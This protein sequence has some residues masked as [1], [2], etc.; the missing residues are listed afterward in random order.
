MQG[1]RGIMS[2]TTKD[3][4]QMLLFDGAMGTYY[5]QRYQ[6]ET[7]AEEA[8]LSHPDQII[9]IHKAY[10]EA[11]ARVIRTNTFAINHVLFPDQKMAK[12]ALVQAVSHARRAVEESG[13]EVVIAGSIGPIRQD[14]LDTD[15]AVEAEYK[16]LVAAFMEQ[17]I[18]TIMLETFSQP[19][20]IRMLAEWIKKEYGKATLLVSFSVGLSGYTKFGFS[21]Q[22]LIN[23]FFSMEEIDA[24]GFN[25]G[26]GAA[27]LKK[28]LQSVTF[29]FEKP[30]FVLPNA[31]YQHEI[32]GRL[33]YAFDTAYY[34]KQMEE[35]LALGVDFIGGCCGTTPQ[36]IA[37]L[38]KM[39][40]DTDQKKCHKKLKSSQRPAQVAT[41]N[42]FIEKLNRGEKV[43]VVELDS[44]FGADAG[45]FQKGAYALAQ[46]G[47]DMVTVSDSPMARAR[48]D[49]SLMA[50][51]MKQQADVSVMPHIACRD[52]NL[53]GLRSE[54][55]GAYIN[56]IRD[57]LIIT[58]DPV[59]RDDRGAIT[60]V[61]DVNSIRLMEYVKNMNREVFSDDPVYYGGALNY[62]G[63]NIT[64]IAGRMKEKIEQ[65]V[66]YFLTQPVFSEEDIA[67]IK[68]LKELVE[69]KI[70]CGIMPLVSYKNALFMHNEM[71]GIHVPDE[72]LF[73]YRPDMSRE[74]AEQT[75][76]SVCVE[77]AKKLYGVADGFYLMTPFGRVNLVNRIIKEIKKIDK[78]GV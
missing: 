13:K 73:K 70:I 10:I 40:A 58:G 34:A 43:Y 65:G 44:P 72:V 9:A 49:A 23:E 12:E 50:V 78:T 31:G 35:I 69:T 71:P 20:W 5:N 1:K 37:A 57:F 53:I 11:G 54:L 63:V 75:A 29:P 46:E 52:R 30:F 21:M 74:E 42:A 68:E 17:G 64:A 22:E 51:Y 39:L 60:G 7:E 48:A 36:H 45:K 8:N 77:A 3:Q 26:V 61:F 59:S 18:T 24:M 4:K 47:V 33:T 14:L 15:E 27:H 32:R 62:S 76:I 56:G 41:K 28:L 6:S 25:C 16:S 38:A 66:S 67:R 19:K 55:I 2:L